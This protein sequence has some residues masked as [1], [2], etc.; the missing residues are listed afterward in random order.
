MFKSNNLCSTDTNTDTEH[1][2]SK[3]IGVRTWQKK[4]KKIFILYQ[5]KCIYMYN[6][7]ASIYKQAY[8]QNIKL[9]IY[10]QKIRKIA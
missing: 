8:I 6:H 1:G 2:I 4:N 3:K 5:W 7:E 9:L 10:P